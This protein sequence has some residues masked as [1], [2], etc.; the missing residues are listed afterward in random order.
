MNERVNLEISRL[1]V[2][3][4]KMGKEDGLGKKKRKEGEKKAKM[5]SIKISQIFRLLDTN[6]WSPWLTRSL[7][8]GHDS[9]YVATNS[10]VSHYHQ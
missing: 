7:K 6:S 8:T 9:F 5:V 10:S 1:E 4:G 2:I 3:K